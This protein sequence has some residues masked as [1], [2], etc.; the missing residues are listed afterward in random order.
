M[1][2]LL[3]LE[4]QYYNDKNDSSTGAVRVF[5]DN[6][7]RLDAYESVRQQMINTVEYYLE[8]YANILED[9]PNM[10]G[11]QERLKDV[12][13]LLSRAIDQFGDPEKA[14]N[15]KEPYS[16][17]GFHMKKSRFKILQEELLED[18]T[19]LENSRILQDYKGNVINP[20]NLAAPSTMM[21]ISNIIKVEKDEDG[22]QLYQ[23]VRVRVVQTD[24]G[25]REIFKKAHE[26]EQKEWE[27]LWETIKKGN[28]SPVDARGWWD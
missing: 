8:Q 20:K 22:G 24:E 9:D 6:V 1:D 16:V 19:D 13:D 28:K 3:G 11:E 12:I 17:V 15:K 7:N 5:S 25:V 10:I 23:M 26:L 14:F 18:P 27:E 21:V 4:V 2:N